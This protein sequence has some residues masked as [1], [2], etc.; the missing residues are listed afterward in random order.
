MIAQAL[1]KEV[2]CV[3]VVDDGSP[4]PLQIQPPVRLCRHFE[5][6][7]YGDA[8]HTAM[9][10]ARSEKF[11]ALILV[12]GDGQHDIRYVQQLLKQLDGCDVAV[13]NRMHHNSTHVGLP[14]PVERREA[15]DFMRAA[16]KR[17]HPQSQLN[18]FFSGFLAFRLKALPRNMDLRGSLYASPARMWPCLAGA[19]LSIAE[20][21]IPCIYLSSNNNF[22]RQYA[23]MEELGHHIVDEFTESSV[24]YLGK[25]RESVLIAL[26]EELRTGCYESVRSWFEPA[27]MR[28]RR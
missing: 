14:Q 21:A 9:A 2:D 10:F 3:L 15:N 25:S 6:R 11:D 7:G 20:I 27:C 19:G 4:E 28:V 24:R 26:I 13:G 5:N 8:V 17:V 1:L 22:Y 12:D 16:F 18:D 23:S